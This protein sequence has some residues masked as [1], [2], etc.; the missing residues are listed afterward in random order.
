MRRACCEAKSL[1]EDTFSLCDDVGLSKMLIKDGDGEMG[2]G[3]EDRFLSSTPPLWNGFL[4]R[5]VIADPDRREQIW[6]II[7]S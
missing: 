6:A 7:H 2:L 1:E 3:D 4:S 5:T